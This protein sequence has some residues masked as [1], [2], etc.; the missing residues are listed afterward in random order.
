MEC[1]VGPLTLSGGTVTVAHTA[2]LDTEA[3]LTPRWLGYVALNEFEQTASPHHLRCSHIC[4]CRLPVGAECRARCCATEDGPPSILTEMTTTAVGG[5]LDGTTLPC[6]A[7]WPGQVENKN[8]RFD[9]G[10]VRSIPTS[11]SKETH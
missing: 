10:M 8:A 11:A 3:D 9:I 5:V 6:R 4:R 7:R 1:E 2:D